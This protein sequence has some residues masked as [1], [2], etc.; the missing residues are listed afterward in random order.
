[1]KRKVYLGRAVDSR[2]L[3]ALR[4]LNFQDTGIKLVPIE[5][6]F[7][8]AGK[9]RFHG[10]LGCSHGVVGRPHVLSPY[11]LCCGCG[12]EALSKTVQNVPLE[13]F[14]SGESGRNPY[15]QFLSNLDCNVCSRN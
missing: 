4:T 3:F 2:V 14:H 15:S 13:N 10:N 12:L 6:V 11:L 5:H 7:A 1:M 8:L 9:H